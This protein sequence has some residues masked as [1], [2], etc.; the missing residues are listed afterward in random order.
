M[1]FFSLE[2]KEICLPEYTKCLMLNSEQ[3]SNMYSHC[4]VRTG[5]IFVVE[6]RTGETVTVPS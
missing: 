5:T 2:R 6:L 3:K 4:G 1:A